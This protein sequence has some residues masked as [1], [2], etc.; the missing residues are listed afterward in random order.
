MINLL[1]YCWKKNRINITVEICCN[2]I[3]GFDLIVKAITFGVI[4]NDQAYLKSLWNI[5][6]LI[7]FTFTWL[8]VLDESEVNN[9]LETVRIL[10]IFRL[11]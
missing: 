9:L 7:A 11:I 4:L 5:L 10:R 8:I 3:F 2:I 1:A 6:N